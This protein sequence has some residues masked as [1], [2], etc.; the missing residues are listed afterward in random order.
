[1]DDIQGQYIGLFKIS[2]PFVKEFK[3][4]YEVFKDVH[5]NYKNAYTTDFLQ[6]LIDKNFPVFGVPIHNHWAEFDT[7]N[8]LSLGLDWL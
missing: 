5:P 7:V 6:F 8:D 2:A 4:M 3:K 1:M